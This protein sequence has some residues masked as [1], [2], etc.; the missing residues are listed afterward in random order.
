MGKRQSADPVSRR[1]RLGSAVAVGALPLTAAL[2]ATGPATAAHPVGSPGAAA[3]VPGT[4]ADRGDAPQV[5]VGRD[6]ATGVRAL[7]APGPLAAVEIERLRLPDPARLGTVAPIEAPEGKL[8]FGDTQ[9]DIPAWLP[10][11]SAGQL[12]DMSARAEADLA[13]TLDGA[14][15]APSRSDRIAAQ[16]VGTAAVGAAV[17]AAVASPVAV[18]GALMGGFVGA[19]AGSPMLPLGT[20]GVVAAGAAIGAGIVAAPAAAAGAT[21]G[22]GVGA[23][24][25]YLAPATP[26]GE[27]DSGTSDADTPEPGVAQSDAG[28]AA[29]I[30]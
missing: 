11:E 21:V 24:N 20:I 23:L 17:G 14:G 16:T 13:R 1:R 2:L 4:P 29:I 30:G 26:G 3:A 12:N 5:Y 22:A 6:S 10:A 9:V 15:F 28:E 8:R 18:A 25:G 27:A 7:P 19:M